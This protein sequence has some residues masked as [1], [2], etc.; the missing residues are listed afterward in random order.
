MTRAIICLR[1]ALERGG[2]TQLG[3]GP[4]SVHCVDAVIDVANAIR[5]PLMLIASRRQVD[6]AAQGGG[7]VNGWSTEAFAEYVRARD[8]GGYIAL[9]RDHGGPWQNEQEVA[10]DLRLKEAMASAKESLGVDLE[11]GFDIVHLDPSIDIHDRHVAEDAIV[12]RLL[13]LY[14]FCHT[15]PARR[16]RPFEIEIGSEEQNGADQDM[17]L[18]E[19]LLQRATAFCERHEFP[20][21]LFVVGQTGTLVKETRNV[22]TFDDPFRQS[23]RLPAEIQVPKLVDMCHRYGVHLKAHNSDYLSDEGLA[24]H[25]RLGIHAANIAPELA[26]HQTRRMLD[27]CR[28]FGLTAE[29]DAFL[30]LA[31]DSGKWKKWMLPDTTATDVDRAIIA[32]HYVYSKPE[33]EPMFAGMREGC[34]R[35]GVDLDEDLRA[36]LRQAVLRLATLLGVA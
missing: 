11:A 12:D 24:W 32:G 13:E 7:Y 23:S 9:C 26:V 27:L 21:P 8:A 4:M 3:I 25:P 29:A 15:L 5:K 33:F 19:R 14:E 6:A 18:F 30:R 17:A 2:A 22:G 35:N 28:E 36:S 1:K 20:H 10:R 34:R 31:Y 16:G